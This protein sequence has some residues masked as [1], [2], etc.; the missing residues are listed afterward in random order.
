MPLLYEYVIS[1]TR[2]GRFVPIESWHASKSDWQ[3]RRLRAAP[4]VL[5]YRGADH[6]EALTFEGARS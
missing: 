4:A 6:Q 3:R 2:S 1:T 5:I